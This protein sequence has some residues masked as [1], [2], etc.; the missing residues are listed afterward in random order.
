MHKIQKVF[1]LIQVALGGV[2]IYG[3]AY[4]SIQLYD[5]HDD[6]TLRNISSGYSHVYQPRSRE[7]MYLVTS[8][9]PSASTRTAKSKCLCTQKLQFSQLLDQHGTTWAVTSTAQWVDCFWGCRYMYHNFTLTNE[10][11]GGGHHLTDL[12][13][14]KWVLHWMGIAIYMHHLIS[15]LDVKS[16]E[17]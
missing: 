1:R 2:W 4:A 14:S 17:T 8:V 9:R 12:S 15:F 5:Y 11:W 7:K 13:G 10:L 16:L 6:Y 3:A